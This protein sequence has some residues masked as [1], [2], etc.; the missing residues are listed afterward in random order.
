MS[1]LASR[2]TL[3][4]PDVDLSFINNNKVYLPQV[5]LHLLI[6]NQVLIFSS[7]MY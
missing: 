7:M 3:S 6:L 2:N 1:K 4:L 5:D